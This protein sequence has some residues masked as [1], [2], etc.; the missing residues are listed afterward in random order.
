MHSSAPD[1]APRSLRATVL[2]LAAV[3]LSAACG[4][5]ATEVP[6]KHRNGSLGAHPNLILISI[7]TLNR[8]ALRCFDAKAAPLPFLDEFAGECVRFTHAVACAPWTLPSQASML[9]GLYPNH[10]GATDPRVVLSESVPTLSGKLSEGY[11]TVAFTNSTYFDP[12]YG[13]HRGF[14]KYTCVPGLTDLAPVA[15]EDAPDP[16]FTQAA[17]YVSSRGHDGKP[18]FLFVQTFSVHNYYQEPLEPADV[19]GRDVYRRNL[20]WLTGERE[21]PP[22]AWKELQDCYARRV[23]RMSRDLETFVAALKTAGLWDSSVIVF[24]SDHGEGFDRELDRVHHAGQLYAN[25]IRIPVLVHLPGISPREEP[26]PISLIDVMPSILEWSGTDIPA[27]L[28]G[29]SF[30]GLVSDAPVAQPPRTLFAMEH[31]YWRS[32]GR[33]E[34]VEKI[35]SMPV[36]A[37]AIR[38]DRWCIRGGRSGA[39]ANLGPGSLEEMYDMVKDPD[40]RHVLSTAP[41]PL[42][43]EQSVGGQLGQRTQTPQRGKNQ[44]LDDELRRFGYTK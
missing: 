30:T 23:A 19:P 26:T 44:A 12:A 39:E 11:E 25:V 41:N 13:L 4:R 43:L 28:D 22:E 3:L 40:Q 35:S 37:A 17:E 29:R 31:A 16:V 34:S 32:Q 1:P 21:C 9:T 5:R 36:S 38:G 8:S 6:G 20:D 33:R 14:E 10:H 15:K 2:F 24:T 18:L 27:G 7:D 42:S